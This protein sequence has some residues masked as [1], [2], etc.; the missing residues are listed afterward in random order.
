MKF[1]KK[2]KKD[3][4]NIKNKTIGELEDDRIYSHPFVLKIVKSFN[5]KFKRLD[6]AI[7]KYE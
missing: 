2:E 4:E 6:T 1:T 7:K 3:W 5:K